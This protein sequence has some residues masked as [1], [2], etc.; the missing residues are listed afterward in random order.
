MT[1]NHH[2][3]KHDCKHYHAKQMEKETFEF[4]FWKQG[5]T[6]ISSHTTVFQ[7]KTN[8]SLVASS[9]KISSKPSLSPTFK[10]QPNSLQVDL[11]FKLASNSKLTSD[12]YK[13]H[14]KNNLCLY[15][16]AED[17]KLN[18]CSKKQTM[19]TPKGCNASATTNPPAAISEKSLEN[20]E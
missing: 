5:K 1:I 18:S 10:K 4:H 7:N 15:Y 17:H 19:V 2:Y 13:K 16:G 14:L 8:P 6:F 20:I 11:S 3:W 9:A 12:K